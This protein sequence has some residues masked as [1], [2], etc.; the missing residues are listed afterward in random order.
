M[1]ADPLGVQVVQ[2]EGVERLEIVDEAGVPLIT[3]RLPTPAPEVALPVRWP[4]DGTYTVRIGGPAGSWDVPVDVDSPEVPFVVQIE[5]PVGQDPVAVEEGD[6]VPVSVVDGLPA[7]VAVTLT[8]LE[9]GEAAIH[10]GPE[11]TRRRL[12]AGERMVQM[13]SVAQAMGVVARLDEAAVTV[14]LDPRQVDSASLAEQLSIEAVVFPADRLGQAD[15]ARPSD[16][17]SLS[18]AWWVALMQSTR[19]GFRTWDPHTPWAWQGV[20]VA[21]AGDAPVNLVVRGRVDREGRADPVFAPRMRQGTGS[22]Q[23]V[24]VLLRVPAGG[25]A[26]ATLP[27]FVDE[28]ALLA[29]PR[30]YVRQRWIEV[31]PV[32][33]PAV[34]DRWTAPLFVRRGSTAASVGLLAAVLAAVGGAV[35]LAVRGRRWLTEARTSD[36]MTIALF[37]ALA[38]VAGTTAQV[39]SMGLSAVLGPFASLFTALVDDAV[40]YALLATLVTLLP[41]PGTA[42]LALLL[43][44]LLAGVAL[45]SF[46]PADLLLVTGKVLWIEAALYVFGVTRGTGWREQDAGWRW[47]RLGA[48]FSVA[49]VCSMATAFAVYVVLYRLY[50]AWWYIALMLALPG[51]VYVWCATGVAVPF[52]QSLRRVQR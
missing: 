12:R 43:R 33:G 45:G 10:I 42:A 9:A 7:Q 15:I 17:V 27:V 2:A 1:E 4:A 14:S 24:S 47:L 29:E 44:W 18:S 36:L 23:A 25:R 30:P 51:F 13:T 41:R 52:A 46:G 28:R 26:T 19:V 22:D 49:S 34:V 50:Y 5:S 8:A 20:T 11:Q 40:R 39:A 16:R 21:N 35:L 32:G 6:R 38:F 31:L 48:A 3:H 37:G